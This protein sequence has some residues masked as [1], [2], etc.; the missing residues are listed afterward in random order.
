MFDVRRL[1]V[2]GEKDLAIQVYCRIFSTN[3]REAKK[4][5]EDLERNIHQRKTDSD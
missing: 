5:V 4:A 2:E 1:I 3:R